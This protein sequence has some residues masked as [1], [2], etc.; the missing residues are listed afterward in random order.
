M[1]EYFPPINK[2]DDDELI[3]IANDTTGE[4]QKDAIDQ[5]KEELKK[6]GIS[7][8]EQQ[9]RFEEQ[10]KEDNKEWNEELK[11]RKAEE[12]SLLEK[13]SLILF[14]FKEIFWDWHL[15]R[16]GYLLKYR[17]RR[18]FIF[19]GFL[20]TVASFGWILMQSPSIDKQRM[21]EINKVDN[22][23]W[24]KNYIGDSLKAAEKKQID[25][26]KKRRDSSLR[27]E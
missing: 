8:K 9:R 25:T 7:E 20:L 24:E 14:W 11:L 3:S 16:D 12:Y 23:K 18:Q 13:S 27:S 1:Q 26:I 19:V 2:R 10:L 22:S 21:D 17:Q 5:A 4:W 6:R 15:K